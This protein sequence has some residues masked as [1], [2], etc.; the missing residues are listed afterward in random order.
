MKGILQSRSS[1][2]FVPPD[3]LL[4][5]LGLEIQ[6]EQNWLAA[7]S[8]VDGLQLALWRGDDPLV[9]RHRNE[10][11]CYENTFG[12]AIEVSFIRDALLAEVPKDAAVYS[13]VCSQLTDQL[14]AAELRLCGGRK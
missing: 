11:A 13:E 4:A 5:Q 8:A 7:T 12:E 6:G 14:I 1:R 9:S 10:S 3:G 2:P